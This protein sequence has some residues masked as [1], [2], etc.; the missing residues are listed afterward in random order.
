MILPMAL[1]PAFAAGALYDNLLQGALRRFFARATFETEATPSLSSDGRL[2]IEP[3]A[4]PSE[5]NVRWFGTRHTLH[6]PGRRPFTAHE[7]RLARS[8][9]AVLAARYRAIFDPRV[10]TARGDLF[11]G[12]IEDR[13]VGAFFDGGRYALQGEEGRADR[14]A[15]AIEV[16][17]VAAL[18]SYENRP[19]SSGVLILDSETDP[20]RP[21]RSIPAG[22]YAYTPALTAIK[23]FYRLCDGVKTLFLVNRDGA[24]LDIVEIEKW[25]RERG[26][27][28]VDVPYAA[29]YRWHARATAGG[30]EVCIVLSPSHEIKV[31]GEGA[32]IFTFR[33]AHWHLFDL[34]AKYAMWRDAVGN[35]DLA[36]RLFQTALDLS[37]ARHGALFV[38]LRDPEG[39]TAQL[40]APAD[41]LDTMAEPVDAR[42]SPSRR[43]LMYLLEERTALELDPAVLEALSTMDGATVMDTSGRLLA[44]GAILLHPSVP[45]S[46]VVIE[47][48]RS[49]AALAAARFGPV[50]KVSE[51]GAIT[52]FDGD[53]IW[54]I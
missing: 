44:V 20:V 39:A 35:A 33:N 43:D 47:G 31:F 21:E 54:D 53:R 5:L 29:A 3:T 42:M 17:R 30:R 48:A 12:A 50:L 51:D 32:Q 16:L 25:A 23:S 1:P 45:L 13:Y 46:G 9:G 2:A 52:F 14:I 4:D 11:R 10:M 49:T 38:V 18:S 27:P 41:R 6:V 40:V 15:T 22:A 8:I 24:V 19:I 36:E 34:E 37:D 26:G 28:E 7:V